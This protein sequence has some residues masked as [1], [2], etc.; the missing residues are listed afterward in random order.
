MGR[1]LLKKS[2]IFSDIIQTIDKLFKEIS[3]YSLLSE[4]NKNKE[5]SKI[6]ETRIAQPAIMAIQIGLM[7]LWKSLG[8]TPEGIVGHS[9]GEVVCRIKTYGAGSLT[10]EQA[11]NVI[12]NRSKEQDKASG[13]G[14]ML[15]T[16]LPFSKSMQITEK[17]RGKISIAHLMDQKQQFYQ[18]MQ[19]TFRRN[20]QRIRGERNI[21]Q[22]LKNQC[23]FP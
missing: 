20:R 11:V 7:E 22:I 2:K 3:G 12:Y 18:E 5:D 13:K 6:S 19:K 1:Q 10:L 23:T 15:A 9:I 16:G 21:Q 14:K 17:H 8:I 4:M